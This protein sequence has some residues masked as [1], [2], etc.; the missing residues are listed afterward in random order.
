MGRGNVSELTRVAR[1]V[2]ATVRQWLALPN[3]T[4]VGFFHALVG[5]ARLGI[6]LVLWLASLH[7]RNRPR[8]LI[9]G[10]IT[11]PYLAKEIAQYDKRLTERVVRING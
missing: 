11:N 5:E 1:M 6:P 10:N 9:H 4:L 7:R 8:G 3:N 2:K